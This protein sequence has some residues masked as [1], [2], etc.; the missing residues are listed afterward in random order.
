MLVD[1]L[2]FVHGRWC[3]LSAEET[4]SFLTA[5]GAP[6][7]IEFALELAAYGADTWTAP[8]AITPPATGTPPT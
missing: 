5:D 8:P 7:M 4:G 3:I 2:G 6:L 1:G